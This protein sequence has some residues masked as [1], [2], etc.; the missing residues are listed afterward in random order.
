MTLKRDEIFS[1][2]I[3]SKVQAYLAAGR[4]ILAALDGEGARVIDEAGAGLTCAAEDAHALASRIRELFQMS[5]GDREK[6]G[7]AGRAYFLE[8][9]EVERQARRLV[10]IFAQ[11]VDAPYK[12]S[13]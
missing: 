10:E 7:R 6:F 1:Y 4:P 11:R 3:P 2:T 8:H 12:E 9:F 5:A 13:R